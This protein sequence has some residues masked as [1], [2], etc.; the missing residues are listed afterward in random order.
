MMKLTIFG[1]SGPTGQLITQKAL[2]S[3]HAVTVLVRSP[4]KMEPAPSA[5]SVLRGD[6]LDSEA[7]ATAVAGA[8]AVICCLGSSRILPPVTV[9]SDGVRNIL[10]GMRRSGSRRLAVVSSG[11]TNPRMDLRNPLLF[12][13]ILKPLVYRV[14]YA[15]MRAMEARV[16]A[17]DCDWTLLRPPQLTDQPETHATV[18]A[19]DSFS[20]PGK[21]T[22]TRA[23]LA[24]TALR[25]LDDP[26]TF[27]RA[28]AVAGA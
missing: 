15:D 19:A 5:L 26:T 11:G 3:G 7:V 4:G 1:A 27:R 28:I 20:I 17:S 25:V 13:L 6:V 9:F 16:M 24:A 22:L 8:D 23:D 21:R 2:A 10:E 14:P 12:E 18:T